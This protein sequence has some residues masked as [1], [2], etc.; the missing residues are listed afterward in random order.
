MAIVDIILPTYNQDEFINTCV[1]AILNQTFKDF[2]F[3]IINDGS[4]DN[5]E[6]EIKKY[7]SDSRI[8]YYYQENKGLP[9]SLNIGHEKS[10]SEYCTWISTDNIS[11]KCH[12]ESLVTYIHK[13]DCDFVHGNFFKIKNKNEKYLI[14]IS[15]KK[16]R[17][18]IGNMGPNFL[19]KRKLWEQFKYDE[20]KHG[21][22]DLKFYAQIFLS[23]FKICSI[24]K[25]LID[26]Y[27]QSNSISKKMGNSKIKKVVNDIKKELKL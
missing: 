27:C 26:Y 18:G 1:C 9:A 3:I 20:G 10:N 22:E 25:A 24:N 2:N 4:T 6:K 17:L 12:I 21:A 15:Q 23:D 11:K 5:T 13:S 8:K 14:D 19:Y 7:L 16:G